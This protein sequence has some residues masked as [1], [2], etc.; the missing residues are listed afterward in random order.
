MDFLKCV[1]SRRSIRKFEEEKVPFEIIEELVEIASYSPSWKNSQIVRYVYVEDKKILEEIATNQV[2]GFKFNTETIKNAPG[3][4]IL[5]YVMNRSGF[6]KDGSYATPKKDGFE[7]FDSGIAAQTF[8]L[9]ATEKGLGTVI[10][11]YFDED[12][13]KETLGIPENQKISCLIPIGYPE[14]IPAM[15][16]RKVLEDLLV[17]K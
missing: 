4:I 12:K 5:T 16:K 10:L 2:L 1:E 8:C 9:A 13:I 15:P 11:G 17:R 6:E 7:M 14:E 3:L